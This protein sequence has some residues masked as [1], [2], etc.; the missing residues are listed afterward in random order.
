MTEGSDHASCRF[1]DA[2]AA[3]AALRGADRKVWEAWLVSRA[4]EDGTPGLV[5][6]ECV[7][8]GDVVVAESPLVGDETAEFVCG[9]RAAPIRKVEAVLYP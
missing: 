1:D 7:D 3:R 8:V 2:H 9:R 6:P 5:C 4:G